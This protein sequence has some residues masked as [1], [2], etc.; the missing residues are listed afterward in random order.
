MRNKKLLCMLMTTVMVGA[1]A[2]T[3][4]AKKNATDNN[5]TDKQTEADAGNNKDGSTGTDDNKSDSTQSGTVKVDKLKDVFTNYDQD[6]TWGNDAKSIELGD[7]DVVIEKEGTYILSGTLK[8]GQVYV[9]VSD[10]EK[11]QLVLNGVD[12]T[13]DDSAAIFVENADKVAIT[14]APGSKNVLT[15]GG[16][17]ATTD[18]DGCIYSKD[19]LSINGTGSLVVNGNVSNG[20][21]CNNDIKLCGGNIE[22]NAVNNGIKAKES[23]SVKDGTININADDAVKVSD[24][25]DDKVGT[26]YMEGGELNLDAADDAI[27]ATV[28]ITVAGGKITA[29]AGGKTTNCDGDEKIATGCLIKK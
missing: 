24:K 3:G 1:I 20:I 7:E 16:D 29:S 10:E 23:I 15:D 28:S 27:T 21:D 4:C 22:I 5:A 8:N 13:C 9:K 26:F 11:V 6:D 25:S 14:L 19:D 12:I 2:F 18:A 17:A